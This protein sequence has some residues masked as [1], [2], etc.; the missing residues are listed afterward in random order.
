ME[1][2]ATSTTLFHV[3]HLFGTPH[4]VHDS[5]I[6]QY[7]VLRG[8]S[9]PTFSSPELFS[10]LIFSSCSPL[11]RVVFSLVWGQLPKKEKNKKRRI[12]F[13]NDVN[14]YGPVKGGAV[15]YIKEKEGCLYRLRQRKWFHIH[16]HLQCEESYW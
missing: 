7:T 4:L 15:Y 10:S 8:I 5:P 16:F 9:I 2:R 3:L 1:Q 6:Q 13:V 12:V 14:G 11:P